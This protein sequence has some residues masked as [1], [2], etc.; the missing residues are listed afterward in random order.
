SEALLFL[1][2]EQGVLASAAA[3]CAS[4]AQDPSHVLAGIGV[5]RALARGSLRLSLGPTT[6]GDDIDR[7]LAVIP[8]AVDRLRRVGS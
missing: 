7:A 3:S 8:P 2:E 5:P 4:G 6:T 1:L